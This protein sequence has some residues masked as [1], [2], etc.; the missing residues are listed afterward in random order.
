MNCSNCGK[1]LLA[2]STICPVCGANNTPV[3]V[4]NQVVNP[5]SSDNSTVQQSDLANNPTPSV[6][7]P[8]NVVTQPVITNEN[9]VADLEKTQVL[10]PIINPQVATTQDTGI[11]ANESAN[12]PDAQPNVVSTEP[13]ASN[14]DDSNFVELDDE[15]D[16]HVE[17]TE[18]MAPPTLNVEEEN[19]A[20][21][22]G[23]LSNDASVST[24][25]KEAEEEQRQEEIDEQARQD[26]RVDIA[27][28]SVGAV[29]EVSMPS[30][31][32]APEVSE[33]VSTVGENT[34]GSVALE[35]PSKKKK[36]K[37][38]LAKGS[39]NV[40][41]TLMIVVAIIFLVIGVLI[42]KALF[43]KNY[44]STNTGANRSV[45]SNKKVK[46][47]SDG[48]NNTTNIGGYT[49]KIPEQ[50]TYDKS[51]G[52]LLVYGEDDLFKIYIKTEDALYSDLTG[53][54]NSIRASMQEN[55]VNVSSV[56]ELKAN[57][58]GFL[59]F[60]TTT[61]LVN[62]MIAFAEAG[63]DQIYY[64]EI[65]DANNSYDY[66][67]LDIAADIIKNADYEDV[68]SNMEGIDV[69]D[70]ADV[71]IKAALEYKNLTKR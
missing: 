22:A 56:K 53:A 15:E 39:K 18:N 59:V 5:A 6:I 42:G 58:V 13:Q 52:G 70:V 12:S 55:Q 7:P 65:V 57:E 50:Y 2:G 43:S 16:E 30:D 64:L 24:Y 31:G 3:P 1:P 61:K 8:E 23:D 44:C 41:K 51:N 34:S 69:T 71:S 19:L 66:D 11:I 36:F 10:E 27:I 20:Q 33:S 29:T 60:E 32:S 9:N 62:R 26:G 37:I 47:V 45:V 54:K 67:V 25:S 28:P 4:D 46:Y 35:N 14:F 17:I 48:K 40:P 63:Q 49:Y 21:G 68:E 38:A